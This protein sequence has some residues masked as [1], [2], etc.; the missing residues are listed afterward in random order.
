MLGC[1]QVSSFMDAQTLFSMR[2]R[3][4]L[5]TD[6][7]YDSIR[8]MQA[9]IPPSSSGEEAD[10]LSFRLANDQLTPKDI[11]L[12]PFFKRV[13]MVMADHLSRAMHDTAQQYL[14]FWQQYDMRHT[15]IVLLTGYPEDVKVPSPLAP[16]V[17]R[18]ICAIR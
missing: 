2:A 13:S 16:A 18:M 5:Q 8:Q 4:T 17:H 14:E 11:K 9:L 12:L 3:D 10:T 7:M 6:W 15:D 1:L